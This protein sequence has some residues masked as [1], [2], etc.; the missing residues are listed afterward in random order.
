MNLFDA[1][2]WLCRDFIMGV[3]KLPPKVEQEAYDDMMVQRCHDLLKDDGHGNYDHRCIHFQGNYL[4]ELIQLTDYPSFDVEEVKKLFFEWE[5]HKAEG[6]MTFRNNSYKSVM[7]GSAAPLLYG[8]D[9]K[10][11]LDWK[12]AMSETCESFGLAD[13]YDGNV[14]KPGK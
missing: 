7:T 11:V 12:D 6:I 13:L 2:A 8:P 4:D 14:R 5:E 9:G 1:Q 3:Y 10:T